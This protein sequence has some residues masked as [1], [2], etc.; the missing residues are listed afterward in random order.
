[1]VIPDGALHKVPMECLLLSTKTGPKY[2]IDELPAI[3]YAPSPAILQAVMTRPKPIGKNTLLTASD[4]L[5]GD[6]KTTGVVASARDLSVLRGTL[7]RLP[8]TSVESKRVREIFPAIDV[9]AFE[10]E[11]ATEKAVVNAIE[12][13]RFVHLA[14][15][16]FADTRFG[17]LFAAVALSPPMGAI[18][19][20]DDGFLSLH[21]IHR[22]KMSACELTVLSACTTNVG[23]QRPLEAGVTLASAFICAGSRRVLASCWSVDDK[24]TADLIANFFQNVGP[25][26]GNQAGYA[27]A[28]K[29]ARVKVRNT[30][31]WEAPFYWA[32]FV[33][34]G[35]PD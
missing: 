30:P 13:K 24:A 17:N 1:V 6:E 12:G 27:A 28:L 14:A 16:G 15:H 19:S 10:R 11:G 29:A 23:P 9:T 21:E 31:G 2:V 34:V 18:T 32:P 20:E 22:L 35:S 8:Y 3:C 5:Y 26:N 25:G 7:P 33:L 4:P